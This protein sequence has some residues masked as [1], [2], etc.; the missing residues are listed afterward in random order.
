MIYFYD[1]IFKNEILISIN[2]SMYI[3]LYYYY[4]IYVIMDINNKKN[5]I[6]YNAII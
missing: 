6:L 5:I 2:L 1:I 4:C 3:P